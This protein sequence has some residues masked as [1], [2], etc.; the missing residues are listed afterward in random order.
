MTRV[1]KHEL[2][3]EAWQTLLGYFFAHRESTLGAAQE[4]GLTPGHVK[5]L[6]AL[7][8]EVP[9]SMGELAE[10]LVCDPSNATW[11][12]DR[13]DER[14]LIERRPHPGDRRVKTVVLTPEGIAVKQQLIARMSQP[15]TDLASLDRDALE[16]L[17]VAL[18]HLPDHPPFYET[19]MAEH[20]RTGAPPSVDATAS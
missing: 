9:R 10:A 6:F 2:A 4:L 5:A 1:T 8:D 7:D 12:V 18:R 15:P 11:L 20:E 19:A 14:D 3:A 16:Q 13:L 17:V